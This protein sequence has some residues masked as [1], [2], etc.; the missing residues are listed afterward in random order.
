[1]IIHGI[2]RQ[3]KDYANDFIKRITNAYQKSYN[4]EL[5]FQ[6]IC[7][8]EKI[9]PLEEE[10]F[11]KLRALKWKCLRNLLVG[12]AGDALCYQPSR[13][14]RGFYTEVHNTLDKGFQELAQKLDPDSPVIIVSHSL[15]TIVISNFIWDA[16]HGL[17]NTSQVSQELI[18]RLSALYTLGSPLAIWGLRFPD[19]GLPIEI[20]ANWFN[21]YN[22]NDVIS[23]PIKIINQHYNSMRNLSDID[24][25]LGNLLTS[26]NPLV[27]N[28]YW[29]SNNLIQHLV[30]TLGEQK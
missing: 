1:M 16:I 30:R 9:E 21:I 3:N 24:M 22:R 25:K 15:G 18:S 14:A 7:W 26:W 23:S 12:Y 20:E 10:L 17:F 8:Q 29:T 27:H 28:S 11:G 4:N 5:V 2:G 13:E 6:S 19:G